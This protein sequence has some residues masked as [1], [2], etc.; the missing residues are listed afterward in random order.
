V[1]RILVSLAILAG[2]FV[3]ASTTFANGPLVRDP[4]GDAKGSTVLDITSVRDGQRVR[5]LVHRLTADR[6]WRSALLAK[7]GQ[8]SFYFDTDDDPALERRLDVRYTRGRLSAVMKDP[9]G[10]LVGTGL[11]ER[12]S[13][14]TVVV[15][16]ARSLLSPGTRRYRWFA[17]AGLGCRHRYKACG[18][19]APNGG[20]LITKRLDLR[21]PPA[22]GTVPAPIVGRGYH[23]AFADNFNRFAAASWTN[24]AFWDGPPPAKAVYVKNGVLHLVSRRSQG[25]KNIT[26]SSHG[27]RDFRQGYFE[28]RMRWTKG[29][30]AWPA[31]WLSSTYH[32]KTT[33]CPYLNAELDVFE[34]QG[35]E[36]STFY[37]ALH[38]NTNDVCGVPDRTR[39]AVG[40]RQVGDMTTGFHVYSALW[41]KTEVIWYFD[42]REVVRAPAFDST[43]Q[44][45][46]IMF[47]M[48]IGG[49]KGGTTSATP[50]E[51]H[52]EVDWVRVWQK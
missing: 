48:W 18:D 2:C 26:I 28:A 47:D 29:P 46:F 43:D 50:A 44:D 40:W 17:F 11:V 45:L 9:R 15:L 32:Y 24:R 16:F 20:A 6:P 31:F 23:Q 42:Q 30:G 21:P 49:W 1:N 3:A 41:T 39:P 36:P 51:L 25:Y 34:G 22:R 13:G 10:R 8:I 33:R 27:K 37:G 5:L 38:R 14:R 7:R 35:I 19:T 12:P 4:R 52:T